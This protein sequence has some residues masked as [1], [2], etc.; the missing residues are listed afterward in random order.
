MSE[1][2]TAAT[3]YEYGIGAGETQAMT[4]HRSDMTEEEADTWMREWVQ[5]TG[6]RAPFRIIRRPVGTWE[7]V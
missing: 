1:Q 4:P 7:D 5:M 6:R 2:P 3:V